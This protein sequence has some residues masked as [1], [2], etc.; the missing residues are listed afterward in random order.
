[1]N[2][3]QLLYRASKSSSVTI[4]APPEN[5]VRRSFAYINERHAIHLRR[6]QGQPRP[7]TEDPIL[8]RYKFCEVLR[9][10]DRTT[11]WIRE[12]WREPYA[13]H[14]SLWF[15]M[16]LARQINW[17]DS[18]D[19]IG[20]PAT[21]DPE[22]VAAML[23]RRVE[24]GLKAYTSAYRV[25]TPRRGGSK[26]HYTAFEVLDPLHRDPPPLEHA[27]TL[28]QAWQMLLPYPGFGGGGFL[29]YEVVSDL[30]HTRYLSGAPD[31]MTWNSG[32]GS[33]RGVNRLWGRPVEARLN[34][35]QALHEMQH[36]LALA[37]EQLSKHVPRLEM[38]EIEHNLCEFD[39]YDRIR[40]GQ[41]QLAIFRPQCLGWDEARTARAGAGQDYRG[42]S[43]ASGGHD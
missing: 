8:Q 2:D 21:W 1:V 43:R 28:E 40:L 12:H 18:L 16:C 9:E 22:R 39:K 20:F 17:I 11:A 27:R 34:S 38:R 26:A 13:D 29:A 32:P 4:P 19:E 35:D 10:L 15:A 41:G 37:P 24:R 25:A 36:L 14:P 42:A 31:I 5:G 23:Q 6:Q 33:N 7:W 30:R 3:N